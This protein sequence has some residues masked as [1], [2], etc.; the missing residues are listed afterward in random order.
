MPA[1]KTEVQIRVK[2]DC[3]VAFQAATNA[4][5][6]DMFQGRGPLP[7]IANAVNVD[8]AW[9]APG[10]A[11][12]I[13]LSDGSECTERVREFSPNGHFSYTVADFTGSLKAL[14][15]SADGEWWF[16]AVDPEHTEI[17]WTYQFNATSTLAAPLIWIIGT[18]F[19]KPYMRQALSRLALRLEHG[20]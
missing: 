15:S 20:K 11:R 12:I 13:Y 18:L 6:P 2:T 10:K 8:G 7:A 19:W 1:Y 14:A 9:D 3:Q 4:D 17:R 5:L 16:K